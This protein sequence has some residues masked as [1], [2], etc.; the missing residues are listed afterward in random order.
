MS[1]VVIK[2]DGARL[3]L[4]QRGTGAPVLFQH[5]LCGDHHQTFDAFPAL[6]GWALT[7]LDCRG[8]GLSPALGPMSLARYAQD[9]ARVLPEGAVVGGISMGAALA[10]MLARDQPATIRALILIRPAW[11]C[12]AAPPN[13]E[14]PALVGRMLAQGATV[15]DFLATPMARHLAREAPDNLA[16][17]TGFFTREPRDVTAHLLTAISAD[18]P[19]L[20]P[21]D[22][23]RIRVPTLVCG[24]A[25]DAIHPLPLARTLAKMIPDARFTE[26]PPKGR[27]KPSHLAALHRAITDFLQEL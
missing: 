3:T 18:G 11:G 1:V 15:D 2:D 9:L 16:S 24:T 13:M 17:L 7:T 23:G 27:D 20:A 10:L 6:P 19:G 5:G 14:P 21:A 26:L 4:H 22:L 12:D 25:E 8:H